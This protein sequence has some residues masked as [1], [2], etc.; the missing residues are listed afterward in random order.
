MEFTHKTTKAKQKSNSVKS[1]S[2][3]WHCTFQLKSKPGKR[4]QTIA[5]NNITEI[6]RYGEKERDRHRHG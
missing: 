3:Q 6:E 2:S 4:Q 1:L 5:L